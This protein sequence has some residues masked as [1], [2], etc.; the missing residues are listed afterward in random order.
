MWYSFGDCPDSSGLRRTVACFLSR[1]LLNPDIRDLR[2]LCSARPPSILD[3]PDS[4]TSKSAAKRESCRNRSNYRTQPVKGQSRATSQSYQELPA[5][6]AS[7]NTERFPGTLL[8]FKLPSSKWPNL[9][10]KMLKSFGDWI[11]LYSA[12]NTPAGIR[13]VS[14]V[15]PRLVET[16]LDRWCSPLARSSTSSTEVSYRRPVTGHWELKGRFH[17][18]ALRVTNIPPNPGNLEV[19]EESSCQSL[20]LRVP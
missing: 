8:F 7:Q 6:P 19:V 16:A 4:Y 15:F 18:A 13:S 14:L 5:N 11:A 17:E 1:S 12:N 2:T 10:R 20:S 3:P 9:A